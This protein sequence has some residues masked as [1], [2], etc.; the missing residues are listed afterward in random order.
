MPIAAALGAD[1][2]ACLAGLPVRGEGRGD[3]L[4][5][6]IDSGL[7]GRP[8]LLINPGMPMPTGPVFA[9]WDGDDRGPLGGSDPLAAA[10]AGRND[11]EPAAIALCPVV[12]ELI[13]WLSR[14]EG[15]ILARMSGSGA[16]CFALLEDDQALRRS[17][18]AA[19]AD[20]PDA[21]RLGTR[22]A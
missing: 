21:W 16:T 11:L 6:L 20:W 3:R 8:V 13:D 9:A 22:I 19:A 12:G 2:P 17:E 4:T 10:L 18:R 7:S 15:A 1:V 14:C 5:P